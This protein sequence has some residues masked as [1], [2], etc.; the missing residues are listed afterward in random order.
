MEET[1]NV[2]NISVRKPEGMKTQVKMGR[3][4]ENGY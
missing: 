4:Y 2:Y 3:K 1:R